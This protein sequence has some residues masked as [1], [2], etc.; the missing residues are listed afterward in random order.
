MC[1]NRV[2]AYIPDQEIKYND[3]LLF[4]VLSCIALNGLIWFVVVTGPNTSEKLNGL[5]AARD[6]CD[7]RN[8]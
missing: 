7:K 6:C 5:Q 4:L 8:S 1:R 2:V 3:R